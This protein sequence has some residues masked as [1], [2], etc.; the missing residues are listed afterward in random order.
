MKKTI[1]IL[2]ALSTPIMGNAYPWD[3]QNDDDSSNRSYVEHDA[4][5]NISG[6][7]EAN[8]QGWDI[9]DRFGNKV[10]SLDPK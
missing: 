4:Q 8:G 7:Y 1:L 10:G 6:T 9:Y 5:G 3:G 2:F